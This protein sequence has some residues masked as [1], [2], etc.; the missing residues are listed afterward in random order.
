MTCPYCAL[1]VHFDYD[2][3]MDHVYM[4]AD[5]ND[6]KQVYSFY[7]GYCPSCQN[8]LII[9]RNG[10]K[11]KAGKSNENIIEEDESSTDI[12]FPKTAIRQPLPADVPIQYVEDYNEAALLVGLSP[13]ASAALSRRALQ[14]LLHE[15]LHIKEKNLD[16][17]IKKL[18]D[19][20]NVPSYIAEAVDAVR[21][22]GNFAAHPIKNERT[23]E[24]AD[25]EPGEAE[26]LLEVLEGLYDHYFVKPAQLKARRAA[27]DAKLIAH[28]KPT[29]K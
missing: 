10:Q 20:G 12:V 18:L 21:T 11:V 15:H 17:E 3:S 23:G 24:I 19:T 1:R 4:D 2:S 7:T 8:V 28:G 14:R 27:L 6:P 25:V 13:K 22:V 29:L 5:P 9:K 16:Q 26:W